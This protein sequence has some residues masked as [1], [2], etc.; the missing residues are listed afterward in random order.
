[1]KRNLTV[2]AIA[3]VLFGFA[4]IAAQA[5]QNPVTDAMRQMVK[6]HATWLIAGAE[7][8]PAN[9][10]NFRPTPQQWTFG[11]LM[12]HISQANEFFCSRLSGE[13]APELGHITPESSKAVLLAA[14]KKSFAFCEESLANVKDS[15]MGQM[16]DFFGGR[17]MTKGAVVIAMAN[18]MADHYAQES[19][20][21]RLNGHLPPTAMHRHG[22]G[23][24]K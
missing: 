15:D 14:M 6:Q 12:F 21:L 22:M 18:D 4:P 16:V 24:K 19:V 10:L 3:I 11:H 5:Q 20:Y 7:E 23:K 13:K 8:Y 9:K 2:L 1:M 17:K